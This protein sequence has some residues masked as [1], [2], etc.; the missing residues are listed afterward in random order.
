MPAIIVDGKVVELAPETD[1]AS[2]LVQV[3]TT[4]AHCQVRVYTAAAGYWRTHGVRIAM[5]RSSTPTDPS[6]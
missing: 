4:Q 2:P 3:L 5:G 6:T 1:L